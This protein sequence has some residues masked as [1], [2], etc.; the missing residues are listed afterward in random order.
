LSTRP[1]SQ[2]TFPGQPDSAAFR[3]PGGPASGQ[4]D[5]GETAALAQVRIFLRPL[6]SPLTLGTSGLMVGSLVQSGLELEWIPA[7]QTDY[8]GVV[9]IAVPFVLQLLTCIFA[10]LARDVPSDA[11]LC[12]LATTWLGLGLVE[13]LSPPTHTSGA[14]GLLL[15]ASGGMLAVSAGS[16][17]RI[18]PLAGTIFMLS[19]IRFALTGVCQ[20]TS[21]GGLRHA[22]GIL[23][24]VVTG[25]A[26]YTVLAFELEDQRRAILPTFRRG[27]ASAAITGTVP[28]ILGDPLHDAGVRQTT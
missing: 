17:S 21:L 9:L 18:K 6:G 8:V 26:A 12:V 25:I 1:P 4:S 20:L 2:P 3:P 5:S 7:S 11:S 27:R 15:I 19:A 24:L 10:Y 28:E 16:V 23:G 13:L 22:S 14:L